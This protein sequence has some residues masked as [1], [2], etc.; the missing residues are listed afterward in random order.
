MFPSAIDACQKDLYTAEDELRKKYPEP[1]ADKILRIR[2]MHQWMIANPAAKDALFISEVMSRFKVSKPTAYSD[3]DTL[4]VLLPQLSNSSKEFHKWR[5]FEMIL[6]T[7]E[8]AENR[9]DARTME[10]AAATYAKYANLDKEEEIA[11]PV[12]QLLIQ[13][14]V[15]TDDPSGL[16]IKPVPNIRERQKKLFEKYVKEVRDIEDI[17]FEPV[18]LDEDRLFLNNNIDGE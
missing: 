6:R 5:F 7:F 9:K 18:D 17:E 16:G 10:R 3:L 2:E 11:V 14:F 13:P 12:D 1:M 15:A 8:I 4:K